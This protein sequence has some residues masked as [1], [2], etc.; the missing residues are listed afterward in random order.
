VPSGVLAHPL[1]T[2]RA[3]R[4]E[5]RRQWRI[6]SRA[7]Q[8]QRELRD[9]AAQPGRIVLGPWLSEVGFEVLYWIPL[10]RWAA[11]ESGTWDPARVTV[12]T[13]GG[14]AAWYGGLADDAFDVFERMTPQELKEHHQR[15]IDENRGQKQLLPEPIDREILGDLEPRL[16]GEPYTVIHPGMMFR[17]F[18]SF[19]SRRRPMA[20]VTD[21]TVFDP[22]AHVTLSPDVEAAV[23]ALPRPYIAVK[24]YFSSCFPDTEENRHWLAQTLRALSEQTHVVLL[25]TPFTVDDHDDYALDGERITDVAHLMR[26]EDNLAVQTRVIQDAAALFTTYGGFSYLGPFLGVPTYSFH[27]EENF[28]QLHLDVMARAGK[29]LR[30]LGADAEFASFSVGHARSFER[31]LGIA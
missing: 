9:A 19:W 12:V 20:Y 25:G 18:R 24:P 11:K 13:R 27:A 4:T 21:R 17:L 26:P 29:R 30:S 2:A 5:A 7:Y 3:V 28:N 8:A 1:A 22:I 16:G 14:A 23:A 15:K 10:L 31:L 6:Q